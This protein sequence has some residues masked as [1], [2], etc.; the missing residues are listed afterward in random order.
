MDDLLASAYPWLKA[1][2]L[3]AVISW[4][5]GI[6]YLPRLFVYHTERAVVGGELSE[7]YKVMEEKLYKIIM[8]PAMV[9]T[10][11]VGVALLLVPGIADWGSVWLW[12]KLI[13]VVLMTGFHH[14]LGKWRKEFAADANQKTGRF[15]R[16]MNEAPTLLMIG[17]VIMVVVKPF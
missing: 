3:M 2:H 13:L 12:V 4:M 8:G 6:F 5:A 7:T 9:V 16:I 10:W 15:Y 17:I 11:V 1:V 14:M